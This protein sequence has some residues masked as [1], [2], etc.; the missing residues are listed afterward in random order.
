MT[1]ADSQKRVEAEKAAWLEAVLKDLT[2][3]ERELMKEVLEDYPLL[4]PD[5]A[6]QMLR[7]AGCKNETGRIE[8]GRGRRVQSDARANVDP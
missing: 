6:L 7:E 2:P 8:K 4:S 5:K 1:A 3:R